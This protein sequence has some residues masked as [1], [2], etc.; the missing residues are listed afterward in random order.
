MWKEENIKAFPPLSG[1]PLGEAASD[2]SRVTEIRHPL[3]VLSSQQPQ[4][5]SIHRQ[6]CFHGTCMI[7]HHMPKDPAVLPTQAVCIRQTGLSPSYGP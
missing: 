4:L 5:A 1:I 3:V 2:I 7:Q 6:K